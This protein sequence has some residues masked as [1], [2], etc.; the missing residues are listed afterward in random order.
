LD[1]DLFL[2]PDSRSTLAIEQSGMATWMATDEFAVQVGYKLVYGEYP[3]GTQ[4]H[5]LP[6]LD[7]QW[8]FN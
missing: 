6:L 8:A 1:V 5:L 3:F 7:F 2:M 4:W